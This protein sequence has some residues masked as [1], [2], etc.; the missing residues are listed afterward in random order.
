MLKIIIFILFLT[1][2]AFSQQADT[3]QVRPAAPSP[4]GVIDVGEAV[5]QVE[6]EK[7]QVQ[8]FNQRIKPEFDEV[9]LEKS[10]INE[11]IGREGLTSL[12]T[13]REEAEIKRI[14]IKE[15]INRAR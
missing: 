4:G 15:I 11:I 2:F 1:G 7:P 9:N 8:L 6:I 10:F 13:K 12:R 3:A 14:D 5:I